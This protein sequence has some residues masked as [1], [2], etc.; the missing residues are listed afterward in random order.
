MSDNPDSS[1]ISPTTFIR[2][3]K[4]RDEESWRLFY[5]QHRDL[6][7]RRSLA[8]GLSESEAE[9]V[10]QDTFLTLLR[11]IDDFIYDPNRGKLAGFLTQTANWRIEDQREKRMPVSP[12]PQTEDLGQTEFIQR[13]PDQH[14][15]PEGELA[16]KEKGQ[17]A[18]AVYESV[19]QRIKDRTSPRQFQ[20]YELHHV[21][22]WSVERIC[23]ELN[24]KPQDV[25]NASLRI[26]RRVQA[27]IAGLRREVAAADTQERT[28]ILRRCLDQR[29]QARAG[30]G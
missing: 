13:V 25:Y 8:K 26:D 7:Y 14:A 18:R 29:S 6:I 15:S 24:A 16:G 5:D 2:R 19:M 12:T 23:G 10:V 20:I 1:E 9:E 3:L 11:K 28:A 17:L 4:A 21:R 27:E 30:H 22:G